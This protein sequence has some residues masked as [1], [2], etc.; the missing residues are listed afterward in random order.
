MWKFSLRLFRFF[1]YFVY[2]FLVTQIYVCFILFLFWPRARLHIL[3]I[4]IYICMFDSILSTCVI[5]LVCV[6]IRFN[7]MLIS[8]LLLSN[9]FPSK[10]HALYFYF[11]SCLVI[12]SLSIFLVLSFFF[13]C[14]LLC[15]PLWISMFIP[16][17]WCEENLWFDL[18][19]N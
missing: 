18:P 9:H 2:T 17:V 10:Y 11:P 8:A 5:E 14:F 4:Y 7:E 12:P 13:F 6:D 1:V 19:L 15:C 16:F 3:Y